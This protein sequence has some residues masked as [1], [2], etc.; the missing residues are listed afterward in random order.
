[1]RFQKFFTFQSG[2]IPMIYFITYRKVRITFTFQSGYIP[3]K[4]PDEKERLKAALHS[5]LV[6]F[7]SGDCTSL[8]MYIFFLYIPIWLYSNGDCTSLYMYIFFSLHS[9]LVI[10]QSI[11]LLDTHLAE[12]PLHSNLVIFQLTKYKKMM[13]TKGALHSNLVIF[14]LE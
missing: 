2:Y 13:E 3:M 11:P 9:N 1:M 12:L 10:F 7:Q 4:A 14:Q 6:I 8:Y 5:N